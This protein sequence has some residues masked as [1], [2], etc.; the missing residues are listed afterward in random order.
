MNVIISHIHVMYTNVCLYVCV[1]MH[2]S[3]YKDTYVQVHV[4]TL[5]FVCMYMYNCDDISYNNDFNMFM[6]SLIIYNNDFNVFM[7]LLI[8]I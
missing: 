8:V 7:L 3:T 6:F 1:C 2:D 5:V 4:C